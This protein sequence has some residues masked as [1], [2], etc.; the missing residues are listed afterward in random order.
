MN[1]TV[2]LMIYFSEQSTGALTRSM[3]RGELHVSFNGVP[4]IAC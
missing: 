3:R 4:I 1:F 2:N